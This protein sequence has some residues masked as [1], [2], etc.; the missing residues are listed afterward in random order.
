MA[1]D[2]SEDSSNLLREYGEVV[3]NRLWRF[4]H[5][6]ESVRELSENLRW[7]LIVIAWVVNGLDFARRLLCRFVRT[8]RT[9][10]IVPAAFDG[11][12]QTL[13]IIRAIGVFVA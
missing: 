8:L 10:P 6:T 13:F 9:A 2:G 1:F 3:I 11:M 4:F 5:S 7:H 12:I